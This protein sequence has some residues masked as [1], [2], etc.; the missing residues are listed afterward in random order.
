MIAAVLVVAAAAGAYRSWYLPSHRPILVGAKPI[1]AH[2]LEMIPVTPLAQVP[3]SD[4]ARTDVADTLRGAALSL[5]PGC[6]I[7]EEQM[8]SHPGGWFPLQKLTSEYFAA[9]GMRLQTDAQMQFDGY[10]FRD[11][12]W[13]TA[14]PRALFDDRSVVAVSY[15]APLTPG[16]RE[17]M[18]GFFVM[19]PE[20]SR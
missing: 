4:A 7:T 5:K 18:L 19:T 3:V 12:T 16:Y 8:F 20:E 10:A 2:K 14:W 17:S 6:R 11:L 13:G 1:P 9:F 15:Y